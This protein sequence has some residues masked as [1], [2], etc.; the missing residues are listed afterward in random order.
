MKKTLGFFGTIIAASIGTFVGLGA[1]CAILK[2]AEDAIDEDDCPDE[3]LC[4]GECETCSCC[5]HC[6]LAGDCPEE[7]ICDGD[8]DDCDC[9]DCDWHGHCIVEDE[10][11][12]RRQ[13]AEAAAERAA[14]KEAEA[15]TAK[16]AAED[17]AA[18]AAAEERVR[19]DAQAAAELAAEKAAGIF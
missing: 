16:L 2:L 19:Q 5:D 6:E 10:C 3:E 7:G 14:Q 4:D 1:A 18:E 15:K 8:C 12:C 17:A 11:E 9:R 13:A